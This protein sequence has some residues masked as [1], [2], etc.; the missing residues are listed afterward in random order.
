MRLM[1]LRAVLGIGHRLT[2]RT[3]TQV[4]GHALALMKDLHRGDG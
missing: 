3:G 1:R 4:G 2:P